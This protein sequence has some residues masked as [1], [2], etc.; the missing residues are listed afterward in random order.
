[1][2]TVV[3]EFMVLALVIV[4]TGTVLSHCADLIAE[5]TG[6]GRLLV[7]SVLLAGATSLPELTVDITAVRIGLADLAAG[8]LLG[9]S[10]M[11][12]L[13]L[14]LLDLSHH[15]R[16]RMFSR[17]AAAHSLSATLSIALTALV[18]VAIFT[19]ERLPAPSWLGVS[20]PTWGIAVAYA[21]GVRMVFVDQ[22]VSAA[23]AATHV[24]VEHARP[25][26]PLW[27]PVTGFLV[28]TV[29][30]IFAGP[31][32]AHTAGK[33]AELSGLGNS[34]VGTTLVAFSTSLPE[35]VSSLAALRMRAFDLAIGNVF[36][37]NAFNMLI[38]VPLDLVHSGPIFS[39]VSA[40]HTL[41]CLAVVVATSVAILGQLYRVE[42]RRRLVEPDAWLVIAIVIGALWL[43]YQ[44]PA[45]GN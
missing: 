12:L 8:D 17:E 19:A 42:T 9:S 10:L 39:A 30:L 24:D 36:G 7:G 5:I 31:R 18:G 27:K 40:T 11:N 6:F 4:V 13:I 16:G 21:L 44:M 28:A 45:S 43:V 26:T 37:S 32:L 3:G 2:A 34:F 14:A 25:T 22:R 15:S 38:F 35:L 23:A 1:M 20:L 29:V 33:L 41:T